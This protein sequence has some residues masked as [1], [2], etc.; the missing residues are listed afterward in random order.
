MTDKTLTSR[1]IDKEKFAKFVNKYVYWWGGCRPDPDVDAALRFMLAKCPRFV[2]NMAREQFGFTN[3]DFIR[4]LKGT[5]P[6]TLLG[7]RDREKV[8]RDKRQV[9][10]RPALAVSKKFSGGLGL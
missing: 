1:V 10:D 2:E 5:P 7:G 8:E 4:A 6:R 9:G 3:D